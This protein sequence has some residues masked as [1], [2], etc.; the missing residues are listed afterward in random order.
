MIEPAPP[1]IIT[2][3]GAVARLFD[4]TGHITLVTT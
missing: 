2:T 4:D 1:S 3:E